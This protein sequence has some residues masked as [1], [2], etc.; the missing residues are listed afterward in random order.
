MI[1]LLNK[2]GVQE[3]FEEM[4]KKKLYLEPYH[5]ELD[6][7]AGVST[8]FCT[9]PNTGVQSMFGI[10]TQIPSAPGALTLVKPD[11]VG[12]G[13]IVL[14]NANEGSYLPHMFLQLTSTV[15]TQ[16]LSMGWKIFI[17]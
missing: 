16:I 11:F 9:I 14:S 17:Q 8:I 10:I 4:S 6:I 5:F 13:E 3:F 1:D 2:K 12:G 7:L 15:D